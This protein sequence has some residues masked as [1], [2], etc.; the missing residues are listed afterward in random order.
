MLEQVREDVVPD[1]GGSIS[2]TVFNMCS[3][4]LGAGALSLPLAISQTGMLL[5]PALLVATAVATHYSV[6]LLVCA[7]I[8]T[9]TRSYEE[10]TVYLFGKR[11]GMVVELNIIVFC[12]G[13]VVAY[14]VAVG[15]IL[16]PLIRMPAVKAL[17]PWL[18]RSTAMCIVWG[19]IMLPLSL[20][21]NMSQLQ[22]T[23]L[24]GVASLAYLVLSVVVHACEQHR[25]PNRR[26]QQ[27]RSKFAEVSRSSPCLADAAYI[28]DERADESFEVFRADA[29]RLVN[30]SDQSF[31]AL[32]ISA[33]RGA[34]IPE[35]CYCTA[36]PWPPVAAPLLLAQSS[37]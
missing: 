7:L 12:F 10:L 2:G 6:D 28:L 31:A 37:D 29:P 27:R 15:D 11:T 19:T 24:F 13:T 25:R 23:S 17:A 34:S 33:P 26:P 32:A 36:K 18:D 30:A 21:D 35:L 4:T 3:S 14:T 9:K 5:G 16:L 20:A 8:E 1:G 22:C